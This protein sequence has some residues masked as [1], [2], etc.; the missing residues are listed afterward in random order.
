MESIDLLLIIPAVVTAFVICYVSMP[1]IISVAE[2]KNFIDSPDGGRKVHGKVTP[3]LG[4]IGIFSAFIISYSVWGQASALDSYPFFIA[5]LFMLFLIGIKDD[6]LVLSRKQKVLVQV[7]ASLLLVV[8]GKV[9]LTDLDGLFGLGEIPWFAGVAVSVF[10]MVAIVNSFNLIDGVDGL[11]GGIGVVVSG[12][13]GIWFWGA[14]FLSLAILAF[15]LTGALVGFL[16]F[17]MYPARIFMG[18]TGSLATGFILGFLALEFLAI[19]SSIAGEGWHLANAHVFAISVLIVP[20]VDT[21]RVAVLRALKGKSPFIADRNHT[22]HKLI[23]AGMPPHYAAFSLWLANLLIIGFAFSTSYLEANIQLVAVLTAGFLILP[24]IR[25]LFL[26][27]QRLIGS[28]TSKEKR[29]TSA[30]YDMN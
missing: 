30:A 11:A 4:G 8:G 17:N 27:T 2:L 28:S 22:H 13:L 7:A 16:S 3:T 19:N 15:V 12:I 24:C 23:D 1:V 10:I 18:D 21:L 5:A 25:F 6:I 14:G 29:S 26:M 9:V 20:I